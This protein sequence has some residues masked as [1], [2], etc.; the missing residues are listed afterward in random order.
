[1]SKVTYLILSAIILL[2]QLHTTQYY[3][4]RL[5]AMQRIPTRTQSKGLIISTR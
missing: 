1:M 2:L 5:Q 4:A 3:S